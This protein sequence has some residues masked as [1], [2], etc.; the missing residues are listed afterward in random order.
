LVGKC[1]G[2]RPFGNY[3]NR[4]KVDIK[5]NFKEIRWKCI[6]W[7]QMAQDGLEKAVTKFQ[8][9]QNARNFLIS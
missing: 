2:N 3:R 1:E 9:P 8:V 6:N 7:I 5:M 4:R